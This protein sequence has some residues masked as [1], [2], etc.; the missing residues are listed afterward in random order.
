[1]Y[2][3]LLCGHRVRGERKSGTDIRKGKA[4]N[5]TEWS[6]EVQQEYTRWFKYDWDYLWVNKSQFV[7]VIFE[8]P[9]KLSHC[10]RPR[11]NLNIYTIIFSNLVLSP[12]ISLVEIFCTTWHMV[13]LPDLDCILCVLCSMLFYSSMSWYIFCVTVFFSFIVL[14]IVIYSSVFF[15]LLCMCTWLY[16]G[17]LYFNTATGCEQT[18]S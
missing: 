2:C 7:P 4:G 5:K 18:R 11:K 1:M 12:A 17:I 3:L 16:I 8:P 14:F 13:S 9:C 10:F 6:I 15:F